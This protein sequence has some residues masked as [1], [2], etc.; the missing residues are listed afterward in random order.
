MLTT[1]ARTNMNTM[2]G[3]FQAISF[4]KRRP[5]CEQF[6]LEA[7]ES[8]LHERQTRCVEVAIYAAARAG[9]FNAATMARTFSRL[10]GAV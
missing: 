9:A 1:I 8:C 5:Q 10:S 3:I 6:G 2:S 7:G 4:R